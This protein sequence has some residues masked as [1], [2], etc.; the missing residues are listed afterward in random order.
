[1]GQEGSVWGREGLACGLHPAT[2][3]RPHHC[4]HS[5]SGCRSKGKGPSVISLA[6]V[7]PRDHRRILWP[8]LLVTGTLD[9]GGSR[10]QR[11]M[12]RGE[13]LAYARHVA[14]CGVACR[15]VVEMLSTRI[16]P[17]SLRAELVTRAGLFL[18]LGPPC[19]NWYC[20][21]MSHLGA[22]A[23]QHFPIVSLWRH[24]RL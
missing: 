2:V 14:Q 7:Q 17:H 8:P 20:P 18:T 1:M 4:R 13:A 3:N 23:V 12:L 19:I 9:A 10:R 21:V 22:N 15:H 24:R 11:P 16:W 6:T 5:A